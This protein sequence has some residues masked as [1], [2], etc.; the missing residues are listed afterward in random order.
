[1]LTQLIECVP[2]FSVGNNPAIIEAIQKRICSVEG[3]RLLN[4]DSG[5]ATNRTVMTF[6]GP[7]KAV[8]EAAFRAV[9]TAGSLID[10]REH[11]GTHPRMGATDVVPLIPVSGIS[12]METARLATALGERIGEELGIPVY[13][14]EA[15][16]KKPERKNLA[17]CRKGEY[18]GLEKRFEDPNDMPDY[19]P[20][21]YTEAVART[22]ATAVG[23][24]DFLIAVNFNLNTTSTRRANAIAFDVREKGR[25]ARE[26]HSL[27]GKILRDEAGNPISEPGTLK[28][29][30]AIGW[31]IDEYDIAQVSMN[32]TDIRQTPL[33]IAFDE[34][35][36]KADARGLRVTGTQIIGMVPKSVMLDAG[37]YF[38]RKQQRSA[39]I[40]ERE[41]IRIAAKTMGLSEL[42]PWIPE[43][44]IIE[45]ALQEEE[46]VPRLTDLTLQEFAEKTAGE[47]AAPGGGSAAAYIGALGVALGT[48]VANLSAHKRGWDAQWEYFSGQAVLG[49]HLLEKLLALVDKDTEAFNQVMACFKLPRTTE[50]EKKNYQE[51]LEKATLEAAYVPLHTMEY[52]QQA[53]P[54]LQEMRT[55][56]NPNSA[57]DV[58]VGIG[59]LRCAAMGAYENVM[60]NA[61]SIRDAETAHSIIMMANG[62]L[63]GILKD[64]EIP[65]QQLP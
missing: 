50:E 56:G 45:L 38:L 3:V 15:S 34:V 21:L 43:E 10:M 37:L 7:P 51:L 55:H 29:T 11:H 35:C 24:R 13:A 2:N 52:I 33:H 9:Q 36:R 25:V 57:S 27:T 22:G 4:T 31:Y 65:T 61:H 17:V 26:N 18:E 62:V 32:I 28:G 46:A 1:M 23:A 39:G 40:P 63:T 60:I 12:L 58:I 59:A 54:L 41:I 14:Y 6:V 20:Y 49:Q 8:C 48:M 42:E 47:S 5:I 30:K 53:I 44:R 16:A 64:T 19:G